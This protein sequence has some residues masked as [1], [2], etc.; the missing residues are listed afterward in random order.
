MDPNNRLQLNF[1][2]SDRNKHFNDRAYPTTPSTFPQPVFQG[3][4]GAQDQFG[5]QQQ[6]SNGYGG[7]AGGYFATSNNNNNP[8]QQTGNYAS[9]YAQPQNAN[10][11]QS[12]QSPTF[13]QQRGPMFGNDGANGLA[14][15]LSHQ[16][17]GNAPPPPRGMAGFRN[18]PAQSQRPKQAGQPSAYNSFMS[19]L[20]TGAGATQVDENALPDKNPDAY[21]GL[22]SKQ[23][24]I[25]T[26][27][28]VANF[29]KQNVS[30]ARDR[31]ER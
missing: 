13:Q 23:N 1:G 22:N 31:N 17:L 30:R 19:P 25:L 29:F 28:Y 15:Q 27:D 20:N 7:G 6:Q 3:Q 4:A 10:Y 16:H 21:S 12:F 9:Q 14:S 18:Q 5:Q 26:G 24:G 8:P 11:Q 2:G